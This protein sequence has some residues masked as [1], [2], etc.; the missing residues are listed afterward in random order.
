MTNYSTHFHTQQH[1]SIYIYMMMKYIYIYISYVHIWRYH[2]SFICA[3]INAVIFPIGRW[4]SI[5]RV[6]APG[7]PW[8]WLP[9]I[10]PMFW[11]W[12][13]HIVAIKETWVATHNKFT[14][15]Y[16]MHYTCHLH[17]WSM[18]PYHTLSDSNRSDR[19][20]RSKQTKK[21]RNVTFHSCPSHPSDASVMW[22]A[23][24]TRRSCDHRR[25]APW[26]YRGSGAP[27]RGAN[28]KAAANWRIIP[29]IMTGKWF[30]VVCLVC[31][32][33][34]RVWWVSSWKGDGSS[35]KNIVS[36]VDM[37]DVY[38]CL[39]LC[40][41]LESQFNARSKFAKFVASVRPG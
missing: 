17:G 40:F 2:R 23:A 20:N 3:T 28:G 14:Y 15:I 18:E 5:G 7:F 26:R 29:R 25:R 8:E 32:F 24:R 4:S 39:L 21:K 1:L 10:N 13:I 19:S 33:L 35:K 38:L 30:M 27:R 36:M 16:I 34:F 41:W 11:S 31:D 9:P 37:F 12:L 22:W 6:P